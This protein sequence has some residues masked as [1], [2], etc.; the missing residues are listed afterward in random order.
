V[1]EYSATTHGQ[2][3]LSRA[4]CQ[5]AK[6]RVFGSSVVACSM[7]I[8]LAATPTAAHT[9][10]HT[11]THRATAMLLLGK[12]TRTHNHACAHT[13][14]HTHEHTQPGQEGA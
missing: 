3:V 6:C 4:K 8:A 2:Q 5:M 7:C 14:S 1:A 13:L 10:I 11:R 9:L 12:H